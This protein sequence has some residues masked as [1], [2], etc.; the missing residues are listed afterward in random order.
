MKALLQKKN[1]KF[2]QKKFSKSFVCVENKKS[3]FIGALKKVPPKNRQVGQL[4]TSIGF[5]W[6]QKLMF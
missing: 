6:T 4:T 1:W 3:C 5:S 2:K